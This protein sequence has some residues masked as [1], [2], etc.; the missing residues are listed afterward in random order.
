MERSSFDGVLH[1]PGETS[2]PGHL[3]HHTNHL[4]TFT[5]DS[6]DSKV[7]RP[8][9]I[10]SSKGLPSATRSCRILPALFRDTQ[11]GDLLCRRGMNP[12]SL[13]DV[14]KCATELHGRAE[15]LHHLPSIGTKIMQPEH[16]VG[17]LVHNGLTKS[18]VFSSCGRNAP[19][20]RHEVLVINHQV[21]LPEFCQGIVL[22]PPC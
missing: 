11:G 6:F 10:K 1:E 4:S 21:L 2:L 3:Q 8:S 9:R 5:F 16:L 18:L 22:C 14:L 19:L 13:D 20:E 12:D 17:M 7:K 15:S